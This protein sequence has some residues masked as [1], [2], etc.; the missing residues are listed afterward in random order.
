[1]KNELKEH[2]SQTRFELL[3]RDLQSRAGLHIRS[4]ALKEPVDGMDDLK[5]QMDMRVP[6]RS[7]AVG[8]FFAQTPRLFITTYLLNLYFAR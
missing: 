2:G 8:D 4:T 3:T 7:S 5:E 6:L 1:M